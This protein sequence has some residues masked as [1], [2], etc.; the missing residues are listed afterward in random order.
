MTRLSR[1]IAA[2][3]VAAFALA[4]ASSASAAPVPRLRNHSIIGTLEKVDGSNLTVKT[5][6]GSETVT[7]ASNAVVRQ[8]AKVISASD[9]SSDTGN[10]VKV[11]YTE[12]NGQK[13][14]QSVVVSAAA[15]TAKTGHASRT[16]HAS[17]KNS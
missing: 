16:P 3:A 1:S 10:R 11:R 8:G 17:K 9:L 14:A 13:A 12:R 4:G 7:L 5:K 2:A 6:K 15:K